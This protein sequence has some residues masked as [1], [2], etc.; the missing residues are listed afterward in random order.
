MKDLTRSSRDNELKT[1]VVIFQKESPLKF[2]GQFILNNKPLEIVEGYCYLGILLHHS[3]K[4]APAETSLKTKAMRAFFGLKRS[5]MRSKLSFNAL[6]TLF[7][8]LIKP[9]VLYGAPVWAPESSVWASITKNFNT[10]NQALKTVGNSIQEKV[11]LSFLK[12]ALG[13]HKKASNIGVW[14]ESGRVPLV[15]QS[16]RL[17][18]NYLKRLENMKGTSFVAAALNEQKRLNLPWYARIKPLL[19]IDEIYSQNHVS[20]FQTLNP[21]SKIFCPSTNITINN[22]SLSNNTIKLHPI[23]SRKFRTWKIV[24]SLKNWFTVQWEKHKST[25]PK[26][27]YYNSIKSVFEKEPYLDY[28]MGFSRRY[29]TTQ[30]RMS[31][32]D[33]QIER[34]RYVNIPRKE[35]IC[36]WCKTTLGQNIIEDEKHTLFDCDLYSTI[37]N[38]LI[39]NLN[40][41]RE[42]RCPLISHSNLK[43]YLMQ[44]LSPHCSPTNNIAFS[45]SNINS[46]NN[47]PQLNDNKSPDVRRACSINSICTYIFKSSENRKKLSES[48]RNLNRALSHI[49]ANKLI[50][51]FN[52][53]P[54][55]SQMTEVTTA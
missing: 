49:D 35:R 53:L 11:H 54:G 47:P 26:L 48:A 3:G 36:I 55:N 20:A 29:C 43:D 6:S 13:V 34:G 21:K 42:E 8:S 44:N 45:S 25:S 22:S 24:D 9:I 5:V 38:N 16:V 40:K 28:C 12:W 15:F 19:E 52:T 30:L 4:V 37:R 51:N 23:K 33:L 31:A 41:Y 2:D 27:S 7:D 50:I 32:H 46:L 14:G 10:E 39:D 1:Q 18:L 17:S